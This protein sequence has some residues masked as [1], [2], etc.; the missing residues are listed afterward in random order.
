M[1]DAG[2]IV[3]AIAWVLGGVWAGRA[4]REKGYGWLEGWIPA[5]LFSPVF[6]VLYAAALPDRGPPSSAPPATPNRRA[7]VAR[8]Q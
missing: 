4:T 6:G 5:L 7:A 2:W 1:G 3:V 8:P